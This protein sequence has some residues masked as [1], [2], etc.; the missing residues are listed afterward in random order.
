MNK[1]QPSPVF[2]SEQTSKFINWF[3]DLPKRS[4]IIAN[5]NQNLRKH[6]KNLNL[7]LGGRTRSKNVFWLIKSE[8]FQNSGVWWHCDGFQS[9]VKAT[10]KWSCHQIGFPYN[11]SQVTKRCPIFC[12]LK[13][14]VFSSYLGQP[15]VSW[16]EDMKFPWQPHPAALHGPLITACSVIS[17]CYCNTGKK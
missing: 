11:A 4:L 14:I 9:R 1:I 7:P 5:Q 2:E 12:L 16:H 17:T 15:L 3:F 8:V 10:C 13:P 6:K